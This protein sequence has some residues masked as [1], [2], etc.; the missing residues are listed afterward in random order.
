MRWLP[1]KS[2]KSACARVQGCF[3]RYCGARRF[4]RATVERDVI[5]RAAMERDIVLRAAME[6][7][8]VLRAAVERDIV[9]RAAERDVILRAAMERDIVLRAAMERDVVLRA[10]ARYIRTTGCAGQRMQNGLWHGFDDNSDPY[11]CQI[12]SVLTLPDEAE[13]LAPVA[14]DAVSELSGCVVGVPFYAGRYG[15]IGVGVCDLV[16]SF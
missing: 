7:D 6:R 13:P 9:L 15:M 4:L 5:L 12:E 10:G 11:P 14:G 16:F 8:I 2:A 1:M 3:A